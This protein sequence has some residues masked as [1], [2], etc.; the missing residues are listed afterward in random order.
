MAWFGFPMLTNGGCSDAFSQLYKKKRVTAERNPQ[1]FPQTSQKCATVKQVSH[2]TRA[3]KDPNPKKKRNS[4]S[5]NGQTTLPTTNK[6]E[7]T[8]KS[9]D[10]KISVK[11]VM[12]NNADNK[13]SLDKPPEPQ[14]ILRKIL[15]RCI[16]PCE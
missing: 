15:S 16:I 6:Q 3:R 7:P 14:H 11:S 4:R 12:L 13:I 2:N 8:N 1:R 9:N 10:N 5:K